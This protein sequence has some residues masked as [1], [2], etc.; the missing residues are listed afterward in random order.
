[1]LDGVSTQ[2]IRFSTLTL[3]SGWYRCSKR[4]DV[5]RATRNASD[6]TRTA[7]IGQASLLCEPR[8]TGFAKEYRCRCRT[9]LNGHPRCRRA[10]DPSLISSTAFQPEQRWSC[11]NLSA[12]GYRP[13]D[14]VPVTR[15]LLI[16]FS[17]T[18]LLDF[19]I[20]KF[21][22]TLRTSSAFGT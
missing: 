11:R 5:L 14:I 18:N 1:M 7:H 8:C 2:H 13:S 21:S 6:F 3:L 10:I 17:Q 9:T 4:L 22:C 20:P 12:S 16:K 19:A 15:Y